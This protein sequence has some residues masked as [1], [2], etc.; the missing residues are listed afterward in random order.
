[1]PVL[2]ISELGCHLATFR[3]FITLSARGEEIKRLPFEH[4]SAIITKAHGITYTQNLLVKLAKHNIPVVITDSSLMP[5]SMILPIGT[6]HATAKHLSAQVAVKMAQK[7]LLW[8]KLIQSKIRWQAAVLDYLRITHHLHILVKQVNSGDTRNIEAQAARKYWEKL[9][10]QQFRREREGFTPNEM[11]N[12]GYTIF[13]SALA[14]QICAT[15]LHPALG[16][17]HKHPLN[18]FCLIDDLI[19]PFRPLIDLCVANCLSLGLHELD[20]TVKALLVG[21]LEQTVRVGTKWVSAEDSMRL[22]A[23]SLSKAYLNE[24]TALKLPKANL[25]RCRFEVE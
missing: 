7:N 1:M 4:V 16:I 21:Q 13:R 18:T 17:H 11:L 19:E 12:Y 23:Q 25:T 15:G 14:R 5:V 22:L 3:G 20:N 8:Q 24:N 10:G 2:E 9:F 6:H